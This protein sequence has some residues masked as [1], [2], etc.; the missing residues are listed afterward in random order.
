MSGLHNLKA[1]V[2]SHS[3]YGDCRLFIWRLQTPYK[4]YYS[5]F[6]SFCRLF[7]LLGTLFLLLLWVQI[8]ILIPD[9]DVTHL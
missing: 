7:L 1:D 6:Q 5:L 4:E 3:L 9:N 8:L 2:C